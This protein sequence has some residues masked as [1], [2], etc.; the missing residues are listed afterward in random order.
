MRRQG[1][2]RKEDEEE[3]QRERKRKK[4]RGPPQPRPKRPRGAGAAAAA[5]LE[6]TLEARER[7]A[8]PPPSSVRWPSDDHR[9]TIR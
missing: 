6:E 5:T 9:M 7:R 1:E 2:T 3:G 4:K 8:S